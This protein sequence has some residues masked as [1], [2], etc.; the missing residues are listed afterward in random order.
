MKTEIRSLD[1]LRIKK[2][3]MLSYLLSD[4]KETDEK[5]ERMKRILKVGMENELT[6]RQK[7]CVNS[8]YLGGVSVKNIAQ[9]MGISTSTVYKHI[10]K[11]IAALKKCA[12]YL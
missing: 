9:E 1:E 7:E 5:K 10:R 8:Y 6:Q 4:G 2:A 3:S 11:G 12:L